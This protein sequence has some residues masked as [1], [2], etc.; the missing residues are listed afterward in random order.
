[1]KGNW[2]G[3]GI[4][5]VHPF[6]LSLISLINR[7]FKFLRSISTILTSALHSPYLNKHYLE[8]KYSQ[9]LYLITFIH[10]LM[11]LIQVGLHWFFR[12]YPHSFLKELHYTIIYHLMHLVMCCVH[13]F[14]VERIRMLSLLVEDYFSLQHLCN[15]SKWWARISF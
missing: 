13:T 15:I 4:P 12:N 3:G 11:I 8:R 9:L 14:S 10:L 7:M 6:P 1:M 5:P 2:G